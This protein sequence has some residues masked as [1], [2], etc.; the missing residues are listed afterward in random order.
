MSYSNGDKYDG[1]WKEDKQEGEGKLEIK[2][3]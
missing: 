3:C 2:I 1:N